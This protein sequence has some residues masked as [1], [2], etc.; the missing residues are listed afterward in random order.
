MFLFLADLC[1]LSVFGVR[2]HLRLIVINMPHLIVKNNI[3]VLSLLRHPENYLTNNSAVIRLAF[4]TKVDVKNYIFCYQV[5]N[6]SL[7][8]PTH[9]LL[10]SHTKPPTSSITFYLLVLYMSTNVA[11]KS[12]IFIA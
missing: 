5:G 8:P 6:I 3:T 4:G 9:F 11:V 2:A 12:Y 1:S 7:F 10:P